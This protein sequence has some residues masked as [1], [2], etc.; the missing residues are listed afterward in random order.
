MTCTGCVIAIINC[1]EYGS[2]VLRMMQQKE[3]SFLTLPAATG[4]QVVQGVV[5]KVFALLGRRE[6]SRKRKSD[7][8]NLCALLQQI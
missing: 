3:E 1:T 7:K 4:I 5:L 8:R 6:K 2:S